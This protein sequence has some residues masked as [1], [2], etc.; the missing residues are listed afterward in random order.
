M[1]K[2]RLKNGVTGKA[3][4]NK[5]LHTHVYDVVFSNGIKTKV[6]NVLV[7]RYLRIGSWE[8]YK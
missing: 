3:K 4:L 2:F 5:T 7:G 8:E 1:F 6:D